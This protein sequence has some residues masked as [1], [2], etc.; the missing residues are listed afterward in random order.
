M[1]KVTNVC[2]HCKI[3]KSKQDEAIAR[4]AYELYKKDQELKGRATCGSNDA[5]SL[6]NPAHEPGRFTTF[7]DN[8]NKLT[9]ELWWAIKRE[10]NDQLLLASE[11]GDTFK[12]KELLDVPRYGDLIADVNVKGLDDFTPLHHAVSEGFVEIVDLLLAA[13][14]NIDPL[15]SSLR[16]PLHVACYRGSKGIIET[17]I[18]AGANINSQESDGNT[19]SHILS[20]LGSLD[21]LLIILKQKPDLTLK[22]T[23]G[24][25][26]DEVA[27]NVDIRNLLLQNGKIA[28]ADKT[29]YN[30]TV[31][32]NIILHNNRAD[33][34]KLLMFKGQML[35]AQ[36]TGPQEKKS[37]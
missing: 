30:R 18:K 16:T 13:K 35:N 31:M 1:R 10:R 17:L 24:E 2:K 21:C 8:N 34:I 26:A 3:E 7:I 36:Q 33:M 11:K 23:F 12:V 25:T 9:W 20:E 29:G 27:S 19:P 37:L 15:T 22:N 32:D 5:K 6:D 28:E 14:C 4:K